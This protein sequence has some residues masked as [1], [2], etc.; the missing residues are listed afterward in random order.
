MTFYRLGNKS[1]WDVAMQPAPDIGAHPPPPPPEA[2]GPGRA[3]LA[4]AG[5]CITCIAPPARLARQH[6]WPALTKRSPGVALLIL[7][8]F[9]ACPGHAGVKGHDRADRLAGN[10]ASTIGG[11]RLG[12]S[13][14]LRSLRH[15]MR[16]QSQGHHTVDCLEERL[17]RKRIY[18]FIEGLRSQPHRV[19][20][21]LLNEMLH[22]LNTI[23]NMH[24]LQTLNL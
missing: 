20:S 7:W 22:K 23:Q 11:L 9:C 6:C 4:T 24:I 18:L 2:R 15:F 16:A 3:A 5:T 14:V 1:G 10:K 21:V 12:R 17:R 13:E 19:T 8:V